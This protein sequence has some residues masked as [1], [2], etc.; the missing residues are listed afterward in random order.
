MNATDRKAVRIQARLKWEA[1]RERVDFAL[2]PPDG[3]PVGEAAEIEAAVRVA[4]AA[5]ETLRSAF[6]V[7][8]GRD[9]ED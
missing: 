3:R 9:A 2:K 7:E 8:S 1:A 4:Q 6:G 5:L